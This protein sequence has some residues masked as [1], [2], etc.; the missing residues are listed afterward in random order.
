MKFLFTLILFLSFLICHSQ[1]NPNNHKVKSY[2]RKDGTY[3]K[4]HYRTNRNNTNRDNYTTKPN[5]NPWTGKKGYINPDNQINYYRNNNYNQPIHYS[6]TS[7]YTKSSK[8]EKAVS[9]Y[10][11]TS[12]NSKTIMI[13]K[14]RN[15]PSV[16]GDVIIRIPKGA[17][18]QKT[19]KNDDYWKVKYGNWTGYLNEMYIE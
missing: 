6:K 12:G 5:I 7:N 17:K 16:F 18:I 19:R 13:A 3:V 1:V 14:L 2:Y 10:Y 8:T 9:N 4:S 15:K 11:P